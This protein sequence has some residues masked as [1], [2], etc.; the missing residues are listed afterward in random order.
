MGLLAARTLVWPSGVEDPL[1]RLLEGSALGTR[2]GLPGPSILG[3]LACSAIVRATAFTAAGGFSPVLHF[4]GEEQLLAWDIAA[5]VD[6]DS[7]WRSD[8]LNRLPDAEHRNQLLGRPLG[9]PLVDPHGVDGHP[10][11][12]VAGTGPVTAGQPEASAK[13]RVAQH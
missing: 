9:Q 8:R 3:F 2:R 7:P 11:P 4:R 13:E 5:L 6:A 10:V 1:V 12:G